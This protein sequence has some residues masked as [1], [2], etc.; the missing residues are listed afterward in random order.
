MA[1]DVVIASQSDEKNILT[2]TSSG[3]A[4]GSKGTSA[5]EEAL[6]SESAHSIGSNKASFSGFGSQGSVLQDVPPTMPR[7]MRPRVQSLL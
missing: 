1:P 7:L 3:S 5:S 2:G 6:G 4:I